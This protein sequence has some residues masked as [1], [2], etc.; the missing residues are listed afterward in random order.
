[1]K[2]RTKKLL[3]PI[4]L[5]LSGTG[6]GFIPFVLGTIALLVYVAQSD[7]PMPYTLLVLLL[8]WIF[9]TIKGI[10]RR[11]VGCQTDPRRTT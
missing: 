2:K 1:M 7:R 8:L 9:F 4:A 5:V 6:R 11:D 10:R 3:Y